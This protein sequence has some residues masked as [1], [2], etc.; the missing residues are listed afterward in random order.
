MYGAVLESWRH[1]ILQQVWK[2]YIIK[3]LLQLKYLDL[4]LQN[5]I[6]NLKTS[7][8]KNIFWKKGG[9][10]AVFGIDIIVLLA[11]KLHAISVLLN[12]FIPK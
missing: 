8:Y 3:I 2:L 5:N 12:N 11:A 4:S 7:S 6:N 10:E 9:G 1:Y